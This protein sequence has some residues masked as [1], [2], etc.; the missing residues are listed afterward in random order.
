MGICGRCT[1]CS[2]G[3]SRDA[4]N[5]SFK[6]TTQNGEESMIL[7]GYS[8][9]LLCEWAPHGVTGSFFFL[10]LWSCSCFTSSRL[11]SEAQGQFHCAAI[12]GSTKELLW[13]FSTIWFWLHKIG[14]VQVVFWH[15]WSDGHLGQ[16]V[17]LLW[18]CWWS[19]FI[20]LFIILEG[21]QPL[22]IQNFA[23]SHL[24]ITWRLIY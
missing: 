19:K 11:G 17:T 8:A 23:K 24:K 22:N 20:F 3:I 2:Y 9:S 15:V 16:S 14:C 21:V 10:T 5:M 1:S 4:Q 12:R 13:T 7:F 18:L 6:L